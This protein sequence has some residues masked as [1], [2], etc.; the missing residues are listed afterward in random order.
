MEWLSAGGQLADDQE[1]GGDEDTECHQAS[2]RD[3]AVAY[4]NW[5][6]GGIEG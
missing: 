6:A 2:R 5:K 1:A 3:T 4:A